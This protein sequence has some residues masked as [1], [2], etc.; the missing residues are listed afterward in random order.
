MNQSL[1]FNDKGNSQFFVTIKNR[2]DTYFK[3]NNISK[4]ANAAM[5]FKTVLYLG[6]WIGLYLVIILEFFPMYVNFF[7][8]IIL[9]MNMAFIGFNVCHDALHG[10]YSKY[11]WINKSLGFIFHFIGANV[12][13]WNITHNKVH[14]TY[15]N[16]I[17]HDGDLD[18]APGMVRVSQEEPLKPFHRYQHIYSFALYSLASISWFFRKDYVKF[19]QKKIGSH[20]NNHPKIEYFNLFFYKLMYYGIYIVIPLVVMDIT[21]WQF[22]IGFLFMNFAEGL[23]L[24]LVFQLAH[25]VEDTDMPNPKENENIEESW[26]EHQMRTTANFARK[27]KIAAF[28]CGGLNFQVEHHLFPKVCHIH[29]PAI[30]DIVKETAHEFDLPY[31][32]NDTFMSALKS[33]YL[34]LKNAGQNEVIAEPILSSREREM[35]A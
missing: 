21:W 11:G 18:V 20:V 30:S 12:Y 23:V 3:E 14:H 17:G 24:G 28:L 27:S 1:K 7:L 15:T 5:V 2:V 19:F 29:Y 10:S 22:T 31:N 8:A 6:S 16:I 25:L 32:E 13:V 26:A 33:H 35:V 34:F 4:N 9:G